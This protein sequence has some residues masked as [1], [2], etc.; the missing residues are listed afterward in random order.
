MRRGGPGTPVLTA[1]SIAPRPRLTPH[2]R[3]RARMHFT[4]TRFQRCAFASLS[5]LAACVV[6]N[7]QSSDPSAGEYDDYYSEKSG[8]GGSGSDGSSDGGDRPRPQLATSTTGGAKRKGKSL[9]SKK[10]FEPKKFEFPT[11][12]L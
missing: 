3:A 10:R 6:K 1:E 7:S 12:R 9:A 11:V 8:S 4:M 5:V 2:A